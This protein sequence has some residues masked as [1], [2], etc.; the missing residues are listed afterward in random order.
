MHENRAVRVP[1][2]A[3]W[4]AAAWAA[5]LALLIYTYLTG[6]DL[7]L[8]VMLGLASSMTQTGVAALC[9]NRRKTVDA[10]VRRVAL[11]DEASRLAKI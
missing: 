8:W 11:L 10:V 1:L 4:A 2:N 7:Q 9:E 3:A 6:A 5:T